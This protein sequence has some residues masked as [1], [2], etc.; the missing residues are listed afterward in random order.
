MLAPFIDRP[1]EDSLT[2]S[3]FGHLLHLPSEVFWQILTQ[4]CRTAALPQHAGEPHCAAEFWPKW[5]PTD[6]RNSTYVEPDLFI[7]FREFD[8]IIEA[9]RNDDYQQDRRQWEKEI[10][11]Y[12]N[13]YGA[14]KIPVRLIAVGGIWDSKDEELKIKDISCP[15]HMCRWTWLLAECQCMYREL[16]RIS[17]QSSANNAHRRTLADAISH[18]EWHGFLTGTWFSDTV[19]KL[20]PLSP[21]LALN[22][23]TFR[24]LHLQFS[25]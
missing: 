10:V 7:R 22:H 25:N 5:S 9:K 16:G 6:T 1:C 2:A 19:S 11:A 8:L 4:A 13:E 18:F 24:E 20:A 17:Y 14:E 12:H 3:I 15:V 23:R 21:S